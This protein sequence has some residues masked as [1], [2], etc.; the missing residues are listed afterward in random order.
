[1][2]NESIKNASRF[3][4]KELHLFEQNLAAADEIL[5]LH[6]ASKEDV[7]EHCTDKYRRSAL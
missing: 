7:Y 1:M 3:L 2:K 6:Q 5:N 4:F